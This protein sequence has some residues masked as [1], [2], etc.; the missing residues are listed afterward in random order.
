MDVSIECRCPGE[1]G[2][3]VVS[4]FDRLDFHRATTIGKALAFIENDDPATR[5]AEVLAVLSEYY[6][7]YGIERWTLVGP[8]RKPLE[9][10][11]ASVRSQLLSHPDVSELVEAADAQYGEQVLLPL[12][13]RAARSSQDGQ[14]DDSTSPTPSSNRATRRRSSRSSISTIP[15]VATEAT[16]SSLDGVS[17][18][19]QSSESAA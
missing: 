18:P 19:S 13:K 16:S 1:H 15:T 10:N 14:T 2:R 17:K 4:F 12:V 3:D 9:I 11:P 6:L 8:D 7:L 5:P